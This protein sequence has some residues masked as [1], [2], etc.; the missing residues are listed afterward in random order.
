MRGVLPSGALAGRVA[1]ETERR[2][3]EAPELSPAAVRLMVED[4]L[5][6]GQPTADLPASALQLVSRG[7]GKLT[8]AERVELGQIY[9]Q[10]WGPLPEDDRVRLAAYLGALRAGRAVPAEQAEPLRLLVK[11]G[12]LALPDEARARLQAL[13][14]QA[15]RA[16]WTEP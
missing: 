10:V 13:N 1:D 3:T 5:S 7:L 15:L 14:E 4:R 12:V 9:A 8:A 6:R 11:Q 2:E 16:G